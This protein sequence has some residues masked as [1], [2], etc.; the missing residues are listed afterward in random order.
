[1]KQIKFLAPCFPARLVMNYAILIIVVISQSSCFRQYYQTN[2][3]HQVYADTLRQLQAENKHFI[4]H[5]PAGPFALKGIILSSENLSAEKDFLNA[6]NDRLLNP[7]GE[8]KNP[9]SRAEKI[10]CTTEVHLYTERNFEGT[11]HVNLS[12]NQINRMDVYGLDKKAIRG[13]RIT[14]IVVITLGV[15]ALVGLVAIA[16]NSSSGMEM[17]FN[18]H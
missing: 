16:A 9:M 18:F 15:A 13:S 7:P 17:T 14:G 12:Y 1:M 4:V 11:D 8:T 5:T 10:V 3:T 6:K 2:T